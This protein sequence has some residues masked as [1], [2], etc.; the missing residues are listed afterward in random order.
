MSS[1]IIN[2]PER[3]T[4]SLSRF[5]ESSEPEHFLDAIEEVFRAQQSLKPLEDRLEKFRTLTT[6]KAVREKVFPRACVLLSKLKF[7]QATKLSDDE[8]NRSVVP[9]EKVK[10]AIESLMEAVRSEEERKEL[11]K[12]SPYR[13]YPPAY[14]LAEVIPLI[15]EEDD[16]VKVVCEYIKALSPEKFYR[17]P[18]DCWFGDE[19]RIPVSGDSRDFFLMEILCPLAPYSS[20]QNSRNWR[21]LSGGAVVA[22]LNSYFSGLLDEDKSQGVFDLQFSEED[23]KGDAGAGVHK[24]I[25]ALIENLDTYEGFLTVFFNAFFDIPQGLFVAVIRHWQD[26]GPD[27]KKSAASHH[28]MEV[29]A[30]YPVGRPPDSWEDIAAG[31]H[32]K[33]WVKRIQAVFGSPSS[34]PFLPCG[35]SECKWFWNLTESAVPSDYNSESSHNTYWSTLHAWSNKIALL[36][37][38]ELRGHYPWMPVSRGC[39]WYDDFW[40]TRPEWDT[41]LHIEALFLDDEDSGKWNYTTDDFGDDDQCGY[42]SFM[43]HQNFW[44]AADREGFPEFGNAVFAFYLIRKT[45]FDT[46]DHLY[47]NVDW[48][49]FPDLVRR[50]LDRPGHRW[51][52]RAIEFMKASCA[53]KGWDLDHL[54]LR[55]ILPDSA[56]LVPI[57]SGLKTQEAFQVPRKECEKKIEAEVGEELWRRFS[58]RSKELMIDAERRFDMHA[59]ELGRGLG[60]VGAEVLAYAKPFECELDHRLSNLYRS[61]SLKEFWIINSGG[62][63]PDKN[64]TLGSYL[65]LLEKAKDMSEELISAIENSG[66]MLHRNS[67]L[68][69]RLK[70]LRNMR[71]PGAHGRERLSAGRLV[72]IRS[73]VFS[74]G[75]LH[76]FLESLSPAHPLS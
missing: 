69:D 15:F 10:G 22:L 58:K 7:A 57:S 34:V 70:K 33:E 2:F 13:A 25:K 30:N 9:N 53:E 31:A 45:I 74:E 76:D 44:V 42:K 47:L 18:G 19:E 26:N 43:L 28:L 60:D 5:D 71:N 59:P 65:L 29:L 73:F 61:A 67:E 8:S 37:D 63:Q 36:R 49:A 46:K 17:H 6:E 55:N 56:Q 16:P 1:N 64:P 52:R 40:G 24:V 62:R 54:R 68:I 4:S 48:P 21:E 51:V 3:E 23:R 11:G 20:I 35:M 38:R 75:L 12:I 72:D 41:H 39:N 50:A 14:S 27:L 32:D 66:V